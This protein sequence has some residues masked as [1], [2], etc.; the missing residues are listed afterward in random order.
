[1]QGLLGDRDDRI[2]GYV[3]MYYMI[4]SPQVDNDISGKVKAQN[5]GVEGAA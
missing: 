4:D 2:L 5:E 3:K 1:V